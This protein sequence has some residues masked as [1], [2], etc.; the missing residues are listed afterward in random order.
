LA[1]LN[2]AE[3]AAFAILVNPAGRHGYESQL[4]VARTARPYFRTKRCTPTPFLQM[5]GQ[6]IFSEGREV[7][8][9]WLGK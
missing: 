7:H 1:Q 6:V 4:T 3:W 8:S 2:M 5:T 9:L